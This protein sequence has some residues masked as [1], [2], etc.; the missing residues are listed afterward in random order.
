MLEA[1]SIGVVSNTIFEGLKYGVPKARDLL[2]QEEY[3]QE[4]NA[5]TVAITTALK[6]SVV[7]AL[8]SDT[9]MTETQ[10]GE[11]WD[12]T[13]IAAELNALEVWSQDRQTAI[14]HLTDAIEAG[15]GLEFEVDS[16]RR[17][18]LEAAVAAGYK[19]AVRQFIEEIAGTPLADELE[20]LTDR[21]LLTIADTIEAR[22]TALEQELRGKRAEL[23]NGGFV[24][25]DPLYFER[26]DPGDPETAWRTG[27]SLA[28]VA[29]GYPLSRERPASTADER[30]AL[31]KEVYDQLTA[32]E[33]VVL[34]GEAGSGKST[35]CKQVACEWHAD[36]DRGAVLYRPS[37]TSTLFDQ[38]GTLI[39]AI[40]MA[41]EHLLVVV[42][43]APRDDASAIFEV[44]AEFGQS[45]EVA[46]LLDARAGNW[47][48][49][50]LMG[51]HM[52]LD[53]QRRHLSRIDMP[54]F[55]EQECKRA[56]KHY[57]EVTGEPS[58]RTG[59]PIFE[60]VRGTELGGPLVV[61]YQLAG[62]ALDTEQPLS[63]LHAHVHQ[64]YATVTEWADGGPLPETV[65]VMVNVLNAAELP[66]ERA[67]IHAL[68][69]DRADHQ[70]IK[71][72][73]DFLEGTVLEQDADELRMPHPQW[74]AVYLERMLNTE[75]KR[76]ARD[77][78]E[79]CVGALFRLI[80]DQSR[81]ERVRHWVRTPPEPFTAITETPEETAAHFVW[82]VAEIGLNRPT[83][84]V[85]YGPFETWGVP[86]PDLCPTDAH[87]QW[88]IRRGQIHLAY[89]A[90]DAAQAE[91]E[92]ANQLIDTAQNEFAAPIKHQALVRHG[93]GLLAN[94]RREWRTAQ[95]YYE[96]SLALCRK[97][98]D[99]HGEA[100]NLTNLGTV[101]NERGRLELARVYY[102][103]ALALCRKIGNRNGEA[104]CLTNLGTVANERERLEPAQ[105]YHEKALA[106]KRKIG[107]RH[108]E[109]T[110]LTN[111]G[112]VAR[113]GDELEAAEEYYEEALAILQE[114]GDRHGEARCLGFLGLVAN[115]WGEMGTAQE[116]HE[117]A[118]ALYRKVDNG[119]GEVRCLGFLGFVANER[120]E[121]EAAAEFFEEAAALLPDNA[122]RA[123][124]FE[125]VADTISE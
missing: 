109:A 116:Y 70:R 56:V 42:E 50:S 114:I 99:R 40:R 61:A 52:R 65:A 22:L 107:D 33:H 26:H 23:R 11:E 28:D 60:E 88:V 2:T 31:T 32:G 68:A 71:R 118:L 27:F 81:R 123:D 41:E 95:E 25:L 89:E 66:V 90:L 79:Q 83:L 1:I 19:H 77:H 9:G 112:T 55:D 6:E 57:Q 117:E 98:G 80:D 4:A 94:E 37:A 20:L 76:L 110:C 7:P 14:A 38:P 106:L 39:E 72:T 78:F 87:L 45:E 47:D 105:K 34:V 75:G 63:A 125:E 48:S 8:V 103:E 124:M 18:T 51:G 86:L 108:G 96:E 97:T 67:F 113:R 46:V 12:W 3:E 5:I 62:P 82:Q 73:L 74:S 85:L 59:E 93:F 102:E 111:L 121:P 36:R 119:H 122:S 44:L 16:T 24:R 91:L 17:T 104:T 43:D 30:V 100:S 49:D 84:G 21:E 101:A 54:P 58:G 29:A 92:R 69:G 10:L 13:A 35:V 53:H 64:T 115:E 15:L 120:G